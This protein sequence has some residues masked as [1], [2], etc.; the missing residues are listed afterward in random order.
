MN[1]TI[2][3]E[4]RARRQAA[5]DFARGSVRLEGYIL[6]ADIEAINRRFIDGEITG[7]EHIEAIKAAVTSMPL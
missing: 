2:S 7:D 3:A 5:I 4:E 1:A 6:D